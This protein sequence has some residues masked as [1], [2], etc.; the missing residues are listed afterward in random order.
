MSLDAE[1]L[2]EV[3]RFQSEVSYLREAPDPVSARLTIHVIA[4]T[5]L[6]LALLAMF[7][8]IDRV[9]A[10]VAGKVVTAQG[11]I[12]FQALDTSIVRRL[13]VHEGD[14]VSKGE[15]LATLDPTFAQADVKE[16]LQQ[17]SS[18]RAQIA[19]DNAELTGAPLQFPA[20]D[21]ASQMHYNQMQMDLYRDRRAQYAAQ[22][23]SFDQKIAET[24]A[25]L[26][27]LRVDVT[28]LS[29][30][31]DIA[32]KV[33][34]MR[35]VLLA[36]GAGSLLN[37]LASTDARVEAQRIEDN[38]TNSLGESE[39]LLSSISA[40]RE[41]FIRSWAG[42]LQKERVTSQ[43][44]LDAARAQLEKA[45]LHRKLVEIRA[46]DDA[47]IL[48]LAK[49]SVGSVLREGDTLYTAT[50]LNAPLEA[51]INILA[52]DIGFVRPGDRVTLKI[53]AF[54]FVEHGT[55]EG[56]VKWISEGA[57]FL[58]EETNQPTE[59]YYRAR[60]RIEKTDFI[61]VPAN[62]RLI[63]GMTLVADIHVGAR[64]LAGYLMQGFVRGA[65]SAMR[66]P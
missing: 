27:K 1:A 55:A 48:T 30:R 50:P 20:T 25:T 38:E 13:N 24:Q 11:P 12:V 34:G 21:D 57:F 26:K 41:A 40:D 6:L 58:N 45:E 37:R 56:V 47:I 60:V 31:A 19:R 15:I 29:E 33:E 42:D 64:S 44:A 8:R 66:E 43:N 23:A 61:K 10:S 65:S 36:K 2:R 16:L 4:A 9:V 35:T 39:H 28:H 3:R 53:D 52:R 14:R 51:D 22:I 46:N 32:R 59:A 49:I 54:N 7:S 5:F 62:F 17:V 63:P 18:L